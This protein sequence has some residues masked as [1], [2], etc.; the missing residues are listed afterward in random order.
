MKE[1]TTA[2][3]KSSFKYDGDTSTDI[4][5]L[6]KSATITIPAKLIK[7]TLANFQGKTIVGGF[8]MT[9]TPAEGLGYYI[10]EY[11][12]AELN[13]SLSPRYASHL[14][15]IFRDEGLAEL[16]NEG[17]KVVVKFV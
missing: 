10:R 9:D 16:T 3:G 17:R 4:Q 7:A 11:S 8:S 13:R 6:F 1:T 12:I 15:A 5:L 2:G 14:S